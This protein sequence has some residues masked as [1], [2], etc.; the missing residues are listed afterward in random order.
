MYKYSASKNSEMFVFTWMILY[1][2]VLFKYL[3]DLYDTSNS[4]FSLN[5]SGRTRG[6]NLNIVN[7]LS[8]MHARL[9]VRIEAF[10]SAIE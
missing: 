4:L 5:N 1:R 3:T 6:H 2:I 9:D 10:F 8:S 7:I